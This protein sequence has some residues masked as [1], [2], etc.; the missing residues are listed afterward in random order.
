MRRS[1]PLPLDQRRHN[2]PFD[3][4]GDVHGCADELELLLAKLGYGVRFD[5]AGADRRAIV[6]PPRGRMLIFVGDLVDRGPRTPDVLR[7]AMSM[8]HNG[9]ALC[10]P[11]N[12]DAKFVRWL[13]GH[14]VKPTH[15]LDMTIA[16][17][18]SEPESLRH[19]AEQFFD[20]L[21]FHLWLDD[22]RLAVAHAG[23]RED[24]IGEASDRIRRF[25]L[26]GDTDGEVD[27]QGL[28]IRYNWAARHAGATM[29]VYGHV[30]VAAPAWVNNSVCIDT[31]CC[32]GNALSALRWPEREIVTVRAR[33]TYYPSRRELGLPAPRP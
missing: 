18:A 6:D 14:A 17:F 9:T 2:G 3:I 21:P 13:K 31:A 23:I 19:E 7:L 8:V 12:H 26:Y 15:G 20:S 11:G 16:Q 27:A 24:M 1:S 10:V 25:C 22:G 5:G 28:A 4:I 30:P 32:F 33:A 29:I